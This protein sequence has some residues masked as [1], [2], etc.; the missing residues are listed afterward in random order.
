MP[1]CRPAM[2][3]SLCAATLALALAA[4]LTGAAGAAGERGTPAEAKAMLAK[5]VAHVKSVGRQQAFLDFTA[6][7]SP[8]FDRDL[9]VVCL[10]SN[11]TVAA[12][13]GFATYVWM[14]ADVIADAG[15]K[16][17]EPAIWNAATKGK[18]EL[19]YRMLDPLNNKVENKIGFFKKVG[20][21]VC[22][23]AA[24]SP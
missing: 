6:R 18:G 1:L 9:Y 8:F 21:D 17:L 13:G 20:D 4:G 2:V 5:A 14:T 10:A 19:R 23:V 11:H 3:G 15:G 12:H 24:S 16:K 22:G 7:K